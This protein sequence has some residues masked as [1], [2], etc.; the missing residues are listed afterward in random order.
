MFKTAL[1]YFF[2]QLSLTG[3]VIN[4]TVL[5]PLVRLTFRIDKNAMNMIAT[6]TVLKDILNLLV[7]ICYFSPAISYLVSDR[8]DSFPV[9]IISG[10]G[11]FTWYMT[12][13]IM[14]MMALNRVL[15]VVFEKTAVLT[16]AHVLFYFSITTVLSISRILLDQFAIPCCMTVLDQAQFG[17]V[18]LNPES[19]QNLSEIIDAQ[20]TIVMFS[21]VLICYAIVF[22]AIYKANKTIISSV[23]SKHQQKIRNRERSLTVQFAYISLFFMLSTPHS[24]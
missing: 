1:G 2:L 4:L 16:K 19:Q 21:I 6:F 15:I 20:I 14:L 11:H 9:F 22:V 13:F 8:A 17:Y 5:V 12:V 23:D 18:Y 10:V 24:N 7:N 3:L